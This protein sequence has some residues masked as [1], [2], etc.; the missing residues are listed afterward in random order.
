MKKRLTFL[1]ISLCLIAF[2]FGGAARTHGPVAWS[3]GHSPHGALSDVAWS[4]G[5]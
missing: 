3:D 1:A 2:Y 5:H 4:D